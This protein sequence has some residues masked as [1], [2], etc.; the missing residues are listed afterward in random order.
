MLEVNFNQKYMSKTVAKKLIAEATENYMR[1]IVELREL[2][3]TIVAFEQR[4]TAN[5]FSFKT[6]MTN[7]DFREL[8]KKQLGVEKSKDPLEVNNLA[9][10]LKTSYTNHYLEYINKKKTIDNIPQLVSQFE[11]Q[12]EYLRNLWKNRLQK[13]FGI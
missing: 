5:L 3:E 13:L 10:K 7:D 6:P 4:F 12:I 11:W 8:A 2:P 1:K 9:D